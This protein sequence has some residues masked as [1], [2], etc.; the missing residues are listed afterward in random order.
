MIVL[1]SLYVPSALQSNYYHVIIGLSTT[2][3]IVNVDD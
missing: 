3:N 2:D 1:P